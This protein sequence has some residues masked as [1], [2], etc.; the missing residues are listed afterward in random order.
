MF[1][2]FLD[3]RF[4]IGRILPNAFAVPDDDNEVVPLT[5]GSALQLPVLTATTQQVSVS[6]SVRC[7]QCVGEKARTTT[8]RD[9]RT[10]DPTG[11][12]TDR[13]YLPPFRLP[14]RPS[15]VLAY[16]ALLARPRFFLT[17][18]GGLYCNTAI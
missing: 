7:P 10:N 16:I 14:V 12:Q 2:G 9:G 18:E 11:G 8:P 6:V 15:S 17:P 13:S 1:Y 4:D 3:D 5:K